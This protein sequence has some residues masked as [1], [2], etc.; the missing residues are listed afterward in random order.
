MKLLSKLFFAFFILQLSVYNCSA[1]DIYTFDNDFLANGPTIE[2]WVENTYFEPD[3]SKNVS[4][5]SD[6]NIESNFGQEAPYFALVAS[7]DRPTFSP[8]AE[9]IPPV[10]PFDEALDKLRFSE[11]G[12]VVEGASRSADESSGRTEHTNNNAFLD[13]LPPLDSQEEF[14]LI[15]ELKYHILLALLVAI[16][17]VYQADDWYG[18]NDDWYTWFDRDIMKNRQ[19]PYV[20]SSKEKMLSPRHLFMFRLLD[21]LSLLDWILYNRK[22]DDYMRFFFRAA[23][24]TTE[25]LAVLCKTPL[26]KEQDEWYLEIAE[27]YS[28]WNYC[29]AKTVVDDSTC[30]S[31]MTLDV[32]MLQGILTIT[33][34]TFDYF[35][36]TLPFLAFYPA[37][38]KNF[39]KFKFSPK[40]A[41]PHWHKT[42][43]QEK[44][45][46]KWFDD[47]HFPFVN[48]E[49]FIKLFDRLRIEHSK[50]T[51]ATV[52][53]W[54]L[55]Q[56][57]NETYQPFTQSRFKTG[58]KLYG[59]VDEN[60]V[61]P[62]N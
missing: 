14:D 18:C 60:F 13:T 5:L 48:T 7:K 47:G 3:Q 37:Q 30:F 51:A 38:P 53:Q 21:N 16:Q 54:A 61:Y 1:M 2:T 36:K 28:Q 41:K 15:L 46:K 49:I 56:L 57:R 44:R 59:I 45:I 39:S 33:T 29:Y 9:C 11:D 6:T 62:R 50:E 27:K 34:I 8:I 23:Y 31:G 22:K 20:D 55:E 17:V 35:I 26:T 12:S 43:S 19:Y 52:K 32:K 4:N 10:H 58:I 25:T 42:R 24:E 40:Q